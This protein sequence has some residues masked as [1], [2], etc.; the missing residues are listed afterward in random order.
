MLTAERKVYDLAWLSI[1]TENEA[2]KEGLRSVGVQ[3]TA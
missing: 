3:I 1:C 2:V